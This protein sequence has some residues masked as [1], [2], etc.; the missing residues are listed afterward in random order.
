L[1]SSDVWLYEGQLILCTVFCDV[2]DN[3]PEH[4]D[5]FV[6]VSNDQRIWQNILFIGQFY[7]YVPVLNYV[8]RL[9]D[10]LE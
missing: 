8:N 7:Q 3:Y 4:N 9:P 10:P 2:R 5:Q 6:C 1:A